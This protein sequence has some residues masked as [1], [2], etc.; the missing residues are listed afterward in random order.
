M[1]SR[2]ELGDEQSR[3]VELFR[4]HISSGEEIHAFA[5]ERET[6]GPAGEEVAVFCIARK[7]SRMLSHS[8][9]ISFAIASL[10]L[11]VRAELAGNVRT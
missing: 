10:P 6:V 2:I 9:S 11:R 1:D 4:T 5:E 7:Y 8:R 3:G